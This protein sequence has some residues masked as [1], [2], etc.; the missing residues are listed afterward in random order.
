MGM[1]SD[2]GLTRVRLLLVG[3]GERHLPTQEDVEHNAAAP[4]IAGLVISPFHHLNHSIAKVRP[5]N[6]AR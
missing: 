2:G 6:E 3:T 4:N 5:G 1:F